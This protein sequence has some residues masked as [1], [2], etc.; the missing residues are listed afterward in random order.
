MDKRVVRFLQSK[1]LNVV[2]LGNYQEL[3][4][5]KKTRLT[6]GK[7]AFYDSFLLISDSQN[8]L[9]NLN[10]C[11]IS[12]ER[13]LTRIRKRFGSPTVLL[14]QFSYAAWKG[15]KHN[16]TGRSEAARQKLQTLVLQANVLGARYLIPFASFIYFS[17]RDN[18]YLNDSINS[19]DAILAIEERL[20][21]KLIIMQPR[22]IWVPGEPHDNQQAAKFWQSIYNGIETLPLKSPVKCY[23]LDELKSAYANYRKHILTRNS[24]IMIWIARKNPLVRGFEDLLIRVTDLTQVVKLAIFQGLT[25]SDSGEYDVEMHSSSLMF[26]LQ[27]EFGYDTLMVNGRFEA[28]NAGFAKMTRTFGIGSLNAA[29]IFLDRKA[30]LNVGTVVRLHSQLLLLLKRLRTQVASIRQINRIDQW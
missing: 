16:V 24:R 30:I 27:H 2:E 19:I 18:C 14:T 15:G 5:G 21:S 3:S 11:P 12:D 7:S 20:V 6:L 8:S 23:T 9:L 13:T 28:T 17:H 26:V 25:V 22:E 10:D 29:G 4:I 1:G